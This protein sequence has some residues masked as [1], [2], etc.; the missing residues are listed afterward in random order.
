MTYSNST[1]YSCFEGHW[2]NGKFL[3]GALIYKNGDSFKGLFREGIRY[4]GALKFAN[5]SDLHEIETSR[6]FF[7]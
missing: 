3:N 2:Y 4:K 1:E 5:S 6:S 7:T